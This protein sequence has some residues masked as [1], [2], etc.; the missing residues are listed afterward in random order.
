MLR[1]DRMSVTSA[2]EK[3]PPG[4][5]VRTLG[6]RLHMENTST[7]ERRPHRPAQV[8]LG[9]G[10][11]VTDEKRLAPIDSMFLRLEER[12]Y[13]MHMASIA[14]FEG[15][16]LRNGKG[17]LRLD[18]CEHSSQADSR[19][20]RNCESCRSQ[21]CSLKRR[22]RGRTT[23]TSISQTTCFNAA[24]GHPVPRPISWNSAARYWPL[25]LRRDKPLWELIFI[26][27]LE[28]GRVAVVEKLHH[29][30]AD[31]IAAAELAIVLLDASP[32]P[33][34]VEDSSVDL[35]TSSA[36][37]NWCRSGPRSASRRAIS[38]CVVRPGVFGPCMHP[39]RRSRAVITR[40]TAMTS[41]LRGGLIAPHS[42]PA[43]DIG[44][45]ASG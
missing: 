20:F 31:G 18:A 23:F 33:Q 42:T 5:V 14:L 28:N 8:D 36:S 43:G 38:P 1:N 10:G 3:V 6:S 16:P 29:S 2:R 13:P 25:P 17:E 45:G 11:T 21:G 4:G 15:P 34:P 24:C 39:L 9:Q 19:L 27:G 26:D 44:L 35:A 32:Q 12:G 22:Q 30:M 41:V 40:A 7:D 37:T